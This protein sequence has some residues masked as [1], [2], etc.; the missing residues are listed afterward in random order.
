M[1]VVVRKKPILGIAIEN[2]D[3]TLSVPRNTLDVHFGIIKRS[4]LQRSACVAVHLRLWCKKHGLKHFRDFF[5]IK[6]TEFFYSC[7]FDV[8]YN[9]VSGIGISFFASNLICIKFTFL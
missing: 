6:H 1:K 7:I 4:L 9:M 2:F 3:K 8:Q 5:E